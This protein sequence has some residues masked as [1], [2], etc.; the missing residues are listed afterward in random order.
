MVT[1]VGKGTTYIEAMVGNVKANVWGLAVTGT[2]SP[3]SGPSAPGAPLADRF[4]GPIWKLV[5]PAGGTTS[6]SNAHLF[7]SVPGGSNH[8]ALTTVNQAVRVVQPI[9][10]D[11]FDV[12]IKID[13]PLVAANDGTKEGLMVISDSKSFIT[14]E[15]ATDGTNVHL[16]AEMVASGVPTNVL[17]DTNFSQYRTPMYLR[18]TRAGSAYMAYYSTDGTD[19]TQATSFTDTKIPTSVGPFASNFNTTPTEADPVTMAVNWF[20]SQ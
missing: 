11:N 2:L 14:F 6:V 18:L 1:A 8:D 16:S 4:P 7:I 10:N 3:K 12:S 13:S 20:H 9:G 5:S 15:L 19:W 17:D